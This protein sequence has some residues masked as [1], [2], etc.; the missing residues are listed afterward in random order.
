MRSESLY[1]RF[2][3]AIETRIAYGQ[4]RWRSY[5]LRPLIEEKNITKIWPEENMKF[6]CV[7]QGTLPNQY[8][9]NDLSFV[10]LEAIYSWL[11]TRLNYEFDALT[12]ETTP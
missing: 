12:H 7:W 4:N 11:T 6:V 9:L 3:G 8:N 1:W 10:E 2:F 5:F